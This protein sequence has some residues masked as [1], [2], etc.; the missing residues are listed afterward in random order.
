MT[1]HLWRRAA[2]VALAAFT[3]F[4]LVG[5][6]TS[7]VTAY[8][9]NDDRWYPWRGTS[10]TSPYEHIVKVCLADNFAA[11]GGGWDLDLGRHDQVWTALDKWNALA[12]ELRYE[13]TNLPCGEGPHINELKIVYNSS[14]SLGDCVGW[15]QVTTK[16]GDSC[17]HVGYCL[18]RG[19]IHL[20]TDAGLDASSNGEWTSWYVG[21]S[22]SVPD[23]KI[24]ML[25]VVMHEAGHASGLGH[26]NADY[27]TMCGRTVLEWWSTSC[28]A[29]W[30]WYGPDTADR[31]L[32]SDDINGFTLNWDNP[33]T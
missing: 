18:R 24:D 8:D 29:A 25:G 16:L 7:P 15:W 4:V 11:P 14:C 10:G 21:D 28:P 23:N 17:D 9:R 31:S 20:V 2:R 27:A 32:H 1:R 6:V 33:P 3:V 30:T 5:G 13:R 26:S 19:T 12:T 22:T